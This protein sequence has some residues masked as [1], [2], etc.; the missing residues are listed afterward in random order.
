MVTLRLL[1]TF[2]ISTEHPKMMKTKNKLWMALLATIACG[3]LAAN[4]QTTGWGTAASYNPVSFDSS[5]QVETSMIWTLGY[6]DDGFSPDEN[7]YME[8][9]SHWNIVGTA[10]HVD[11]GEFWGVSAS[12]NSTAASVGKEQYV[13]AFNS[14]DKIGQADG[15]ALLFDPGDFFFPEIPYTVTHGIPQATGDTADDNFRIIWGRVDRDP[16]TAGGVLTGGGVFQNLVPDST[17][18]PDGGLNSTFNAQFGGFAVPEPSTS[19]L[20]LIG[21]LFVLRRRRQEA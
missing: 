21:S 1:Q 12:T 4:G 2:L 7:N 5:G 11:Y 9:A 15:Q 16:F 13:F 3:A 8:W 17:S 14:L 19:L 20:G 18:G 10:G 6:F